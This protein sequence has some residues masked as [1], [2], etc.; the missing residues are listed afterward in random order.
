MNKYIFK[1]FMMAIANIGYTVE[2][3]K[4]L[5][6]Q[7]SNHQFLETYETLACSELFKEYQTQYIQGFSDFQG[8]IDH[9]PFMDSETAEWDYLEK[10]W[11]KDQKKQLNPFLKNIEFLNKKLEELPKIFVQP[12]VMESALN[13]LILL[14]QT[15]Q[16]KYTENQALL[17]SNMNALITSYLEYE[18]TYILFQKVS[19]SL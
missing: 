10:K 1:I 12:K 4:I 3:T 8:I 15:A 19:R 7:N 13:Q 17:I 14:L 2:E 9:L 5:E 16:K 6:I 18:Q 11:Y